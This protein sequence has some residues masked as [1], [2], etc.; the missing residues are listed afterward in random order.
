MLLL[1]K[2]NLGKWL[3]KACNLEVWI[4]RKSF[5]TL[6]LT[7]LA[8]RELKLIAFEK[9]QVETRKQHAIKSKRN[10]ST[11]SR[12]VSNCKTAKHAL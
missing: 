4:H 1:C 12:G 2:V 11:P 6:S 10:F 3:H 9:T 5:D 8:L 7:Q